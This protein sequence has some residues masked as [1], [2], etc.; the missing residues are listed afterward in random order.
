MTMLNAAAMATFTFASGWLYAEF[1]SA[2]FAMMALPALGGV[3]V[4][5]V[6]PRL[7][8]DLQGEVPREAEPTGAID[9]PPAPAA[10]E[11]PRP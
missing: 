1:G 2:G 4:M 7:A 10:P 9:Q 11:P 8:P 6:L 3:A 5:L